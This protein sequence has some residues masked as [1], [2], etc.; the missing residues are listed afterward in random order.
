MSPY[1]ASSPPGTPRQAPPSISDIEMRVARHFSIIPS[2]LTGD[3]KAQW[4]ARPRQVAL[5]LACEIS[6]QGPVAIGAFTGRGHSTVIGAHRRIFQLMRRDAQLAWDVA[7]LE[8]I[9]GGE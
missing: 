8:R 9:L 1:L 5:Y 6:G 7:Y 2:I 3:N 4:C